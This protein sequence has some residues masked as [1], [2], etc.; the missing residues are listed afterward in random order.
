[1]AA[2]R[3]INIRAVSMVA[4]I[5]AV[6]ALGWLSIG[7]GGQSAPLALHAPP[8]PPTMSSEAMILG[9][10]TTIET[11]APDDVAPLKA[12]PE[13]TGPAALPSEEAGLP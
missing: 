3:K 7:T 5:G 6:L 4:G 12:Q 1:M 9:A 2:H 8:P 11:L 13:I 10:T